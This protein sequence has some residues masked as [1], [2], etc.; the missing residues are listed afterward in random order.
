MQAMMLDY[1]VCSAVDVLQNHWPVHVLQIAMDRVPTRID[2]NVN[3][4]YEKNRWG[5]IPLSQAHLAVRKK[6]H[7]GSMEV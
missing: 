2:S 1:T 7:E 4:P 3:I 6:S 5:L